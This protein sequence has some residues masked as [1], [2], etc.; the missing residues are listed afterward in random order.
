MATPQYT[1][2]VGADSVDYFSREV[3]ASDV[4]K[5][6]SLEDKIGLIQEQ[7]VSGSDTFNYPVL[8]RRTG[9]SFKGST[10]SIESN[11]L[12]KGRTK[13]APRKGNSSS[14]GSLD[15]ELSPETYDDILEA[16]LRGKWREW[17]SDSKVKQD[18]GT[19]SDSSTNIVEAGET[20]TVFAD[21]TFLSKVTDQSTREISSVQRRLWATSAELETIKTAIRAD[22]PTWKDSEL[23]NDARYPIII[24]DADLEVSELTC[25]MNDVKY[26]I[27]K[28]FGGV[29]GDDLYQEFQHKAVNTMS[30]SVTPGQIVTGS[31]GFMG[32][33]NPDIVQR[34]VTMDGVIESVEHTTG[35]VDGD[36]PKGLVKLLAKW[37]EHESRF[38]EEKTPAEVKAWIDALPEKGTSTDQYTAREGFLY[39]NGERVRYG[40]NL[41]F[42][43]DNGL[44]KTFAIF[45]KDAIATSP[46]TLNIEGTL[47]VY[48]IKGYSENLYNLATQDKDVE[49]LFCFQEKEEDPES[50]YVIQIFKT[51]FTSTDLSS[52]AENLEVSFPFQSFEERAVRMFRLRKTKPTSVTLDSDNKTLTVN[53]TSSQPGATQDEVTLTVDGVKQIVDTDYTF[54]LAE[55]GKS[56]TLELTTALTE[57][58]SGHT[59]VVSYN[60]TDVSMSGLKIGLEEDGVIFAASNDSVDV[61]LTAMPDEAP[62]QTDFTITV[63]VNGTP[64]TI[65]D[66]SYTAGVATFSFAEIVAG[67]EAKVLLANVTF[68]GSTA[69]GTATID[70]E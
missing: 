69:S 15:F 23:Y 26:S 56:C 6:P 7:V 58:L 66:Y 57:T 60:G 3:T 9:D 43:L 33:N 62:V 39:I 61:T 59:I 17:V 38:V 30:L 51:K 25:G 64:V 46:L 5:D 24:T 63:S 44:N 29:D 31:F 52:G 37:Q 45:E 36:T 10:E 49:V 48:L 1:I 54:T 27:L 18:D 50:L 12:R 2:K 8:V 28:H 53:F 16:A 42:N 68:N 21:G 32:S 14:E 47:G 11:E 22:H 67:A 19:Y 13:S 41:E 65:T 4:A 34:G 40:S 70:A 20:K 55:D 35:Y